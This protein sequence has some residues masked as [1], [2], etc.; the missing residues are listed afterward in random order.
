MPINLCLIM[1]P[2]PVITILS[3]W[4]VLENH[5]RKKERA[6]EFDANVEQT[7]RLIDEIVYELYRLIE[8]V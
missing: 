5:L 8:E 7:D 3:Q 6:E 4:F 1:E 2:T